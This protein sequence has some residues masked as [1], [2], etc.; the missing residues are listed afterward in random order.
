MKTPPGTVEIFLAPGE[1][2]F[3]DRHTRIRTLLGSCVAISLW[4]PQRH[5]GGMCHYL[6]PARMRGETEELDGKYA[7]EALHLLIGELTRAGTRLQDYEC[8]LFGGGNMFP[9]RQ[10][11]TA[12]CAADHVGRKNAQAG[13]DLMRR[14]GLRP[15][16][17]D[18]EGAGHRN[19]IFDLWTGNVW[20]KHVVLPAAPAQCANCEGNTL[21]LNG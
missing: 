7:D 6:L 15:A 14:H 17:E 20:V 11:K 5:L 18:L 2:Y 12:R 1:H 13:R 19:V 9:D 3:G 8:K 4:H 21:C 10:R 16:R